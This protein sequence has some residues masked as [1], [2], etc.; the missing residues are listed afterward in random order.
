ML[1]RL[2]VRKVLQFDSL[3]ILLVLSFATSSNADLLVNGSFEAPAGYA[4]GNQGVMPPGWEITNVDPGA[5]LYSSD[6]SFGLHPSINGNFTGVTAFDGLGWVAGGGYANWESFGQELQTPL[7]P[8]ADYRLEAY[9]I[10][11][12]RYGIHYPGG[13]DILLN[14]SNAL[15]GAVQVATFSATTETDDWEFREASFTAPSNA[16]ELPWII[17]R[18]F[19]VEYSY[20]AYPGIDK[21]SLV[22]VPEPAT[23]SLLGL[24]LAGL[25]ARRPKR[26]A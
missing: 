19:D 11:A 25:I 20:T 17:F 1:H 7:T 18:P 26:R 5:D 23:L 2:H 13:Y 12:R 15:T 24:G 3:A 8:G 22:L 6:G 16:D 9:L 4:L 21:L 14:V 10:R